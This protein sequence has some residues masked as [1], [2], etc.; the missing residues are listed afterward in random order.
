MIF[1]Q[2]LAHKASWPKNT[3]LTPD[4]FLINFSVSANNVHARTFMN[5]LKQRKDFKHL[6]NHVFSD[7]F[8]AELSRNNIKVCS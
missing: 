3:K 7:D 6:D 2:R 8:L 1:D 4:K 5:F